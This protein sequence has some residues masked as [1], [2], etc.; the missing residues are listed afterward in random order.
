MHV[1]NARGKYLPEMV[2]EKKPG[3]PATGLFGFVCN[4][5]PTKCM[6]VILVLVRHLLG[7]LI[8]IPLLS[9]AAIL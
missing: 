8:P 4:Y 6:C 2:Q 9:L 5:Q 1:C 3:E 7:Q